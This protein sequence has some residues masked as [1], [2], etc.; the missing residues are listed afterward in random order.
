LHKVLRYL[1]SCNDSV[2]ALHSVPGAQCSVPGARCP[3]LC[4][5]C[6]VSV[7]SALSSLLGALALCPVRLLCVRCPVFGV[8]RPALPRSSPRRGV[9]CR[10]AR[11]AAPGCP[12]PRSSPRRAGMSSAAELAAPRRDV[13]AP[14]ERT[15]R[16]EYVHISTQRATPQPPADACQ[17]PVPSRPRCACP[18]PASLCLSPAVLAVPVQISV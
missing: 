8:I 14:V 1:S 5:H 12:L 18:Q 4:A 16:P 6:S 17:P 13:L 15:L 9:L 10:G 2:L 11:R 7:L 3:V